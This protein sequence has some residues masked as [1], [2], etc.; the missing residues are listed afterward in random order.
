MKKQLLAVAVATAF[1]APAIAQN[2]SVYGYLE[3]GI[4][5]TKTSG[6]TNTGNSTNLTTG[7]FG[8]SRLGFKGSEDLGGGMKAGFRL[9]MS[10][11]ATHGQGGSSDL[12]TATAAPLF[13]R[14]AEINLSGAFGTIKMGKLDHP[15]LEGNEVNTVGNIALFQTDV[16]GISDVATAS[17]TTSIIYVAP[18]KALGGNLTLGYSGK[19][20]GIGAGN[21]HGGLRSYQLAGSMAGFTYKIGGGSMKAST[22][23]N[24]TKVVGGGIGTNFGALNV[25]LQIQKLDV[26]ASAEDF[27]ETIVTAKYNLGGGLDVRGAYST[28]DKAT[29]STADATKLTLAVAKALSKRTTAYVA[30][31]STD[32]NTSTNND[33]R[34]LGFYVGHSF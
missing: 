22:S 18:I 4:E 9:E 28:L 19:D 26:P 31:R 33:T 10:A 3:T 20:D 30:Y 7:M 21:A 5:N 27:T 13:N 8:S 24:S 6:T 11:S 15:G 34:E 16:E 32:V 1:A 17:D 14:G 25:G 12:G 23:S 29:N 2:V